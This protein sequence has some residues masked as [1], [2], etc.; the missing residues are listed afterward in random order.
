MMPARLTSPTVGLI[1]TIPV[2]EAGQTID[3][4]VSV[5]TATAP[6]LAETATA[7]PELEP[8]GFRS[9]TKGFRHCP[10]RALQPLLERVDRMLAHSLMFALA[11][12]TAPA[13]RRRAATPESL[14]ATKPSSASDPA[15]VV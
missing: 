13:E 9:S 12:S 3:P 4:S 5:P 15:V 11:S 6:R 8:H 10:P 7:E 14:E 2:A 1:P